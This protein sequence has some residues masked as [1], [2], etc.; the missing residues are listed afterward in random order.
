MSV[1]NALLLLGLIVVCACEEEK[2]PYSAPHFP[3]IC[4]DIV[5]SGN[6]PE[7]ACTD[8]AAYSFE[9]DRA[10]KVELLNDS[11]VRITASSPDENK[12][13]SK[14][15]TVTTLEDNFVTYSRWIEDRLTLCDSVLSIEVRYKHGGLR[16]S[17]VERY[18]VE[19]FPRAEEVL[20]NGQ[21][22]VT[23]EE[24]LAAHVA[25][26]TEQYIR[27][28]EHPAETWVMKL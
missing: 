10:E 25:Y 9:A 21:R 16:G 4:I 22:C 28:D 7:G 6:S 24:W 19:F 12:W 14:Y 8:V 20:V 5:Q 1:S 17:A 27:S 11:V 23:Q 2:L 18:E 3:A 13:N 26:S 15:A